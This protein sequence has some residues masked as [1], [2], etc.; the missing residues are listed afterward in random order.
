MKIPPIGLFRAGLTILQAIEAL[1]KEVI[2][3]G[4]NLS[5][6]IGISTGKVVVGDIGTGKERESMGVVGEVPNIAARLQ[7]SAKP[8]SVIISES[9]K[10][11]VDGMFEVEDLGRQNFKG[12]SKPIPVFEVHAETNTF[13]RIEAVARQRLTHLIGR[14]AEVNLLNERWKQV[15]EGDGQV[16]LLSGEAGIGKSRILKRFRDQLKNEQHWTYLYY[17]SAHHQSSAFYP[18]IS[19]VEHSLGFEAQDSNDT[20]LTKIEAQLEA[21]KL[22]FDTYVPIYAFLLGISTNDKYSASALNPQ[23]LK[24]KVI[25][26]PDPSL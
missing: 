1:D 16:L 8:N 26:T 22:P 3:L 11:L 10:L 4:I 19:Q 25:E 5:I 15:K 24:Q 2:H 14:D 12:I 18:I 23:Q 7:G 13:S 17:S 6:R 9:T 21:L 20:K